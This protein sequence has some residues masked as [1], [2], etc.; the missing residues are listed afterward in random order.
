MRADAGPRSV[1]ILRFFLAHPGELLSTDAL[2]AAGWSGRDIGENSLP[3]AVSRLKKTL[4]V[5]AGGAPFVENVSGRGYRFLADV[6]RENPSATRE[7]V[8]M[9][10]EKYREF[11]KGRGLLET[12]DLEAIAN[13]RAAYEE[14]V[15]LEPDY[16]PWHVGL[17]TACIL[18]YESTRVD[19]SPDRASLTCAA[20]HAREAVRLDRESGD[21]WSTLAPGPLLPGRQRRRDRRRAHGRGARAPQLVSPAM[22]GVRELG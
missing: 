18:Q 16:A 19:V 7:L 2:V 15:R 1:E 4:G 21:A 12:L 9:L 17:A 3:T 6:Q 10:V 20:Q 5:Q 14:A 8:D 11:S 22:P 13:A